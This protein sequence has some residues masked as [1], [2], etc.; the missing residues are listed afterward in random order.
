MTTPTDK[1]NENAREY[2]NNGL[3]DVTQVR[4]LKACYIDLAE[5]HEQHLL[6][7]YHLTMRYAPAVGYTEALK[8]MFPGVL[9]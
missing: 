6:A 8:K 3:L 4:N 7:S 2:A 9:P 1:D 5:K